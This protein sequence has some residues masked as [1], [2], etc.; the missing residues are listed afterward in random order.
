MQIAKYG[1]Y[2][3][4]METMEAVFKAKTAADLPEG[5]TRAEVNGMSRRFVMETID[6]KQR[7]W[8]TSLVS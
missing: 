4:R 7:E 2:Y 8:Y 1:F 3:P 5:M 6:G